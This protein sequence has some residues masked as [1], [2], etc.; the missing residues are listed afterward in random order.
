MSEDAMYV[1]R[2]DLL[3]ATV[4]VGG[5]LAGRPA[6]ADVDL[7]GQARSRLL[8]RGRG[9]Y[10]NAANMAPTFRSVLLAQESTARQV[11]SDPGIEARN[12]FIGIARQVRERL[13]ARLG[14]T[15]DEVALMRNCSEA[16]TQIVRGLS[17]TP[18]DEVVVSAQNHESNA[19]NWRVAARQQGVSVRTAATSATPRAPREIFDQMVAAITPRTK[20]V[21]VSHMTNVSGVIFPIEALAA[22][23]RARGIWFHVDAA[24]TFGWKPIDVAA[25]GC[26]SLS[27]SSQK[28]LM[29]PVGM[30]LLCVRRERLAQ[31][32]PLTTSHGYWRGAPET[33]M[34]GERFEDLGQGEDAKLPALLAALAE[35][36]RLG[37]AAIAARVTGLAAAL[38]ERLSTV[39]GVTVHGRSDATLYGPV[40]AVSLADAD[41]DTIRTKVTSQLGGLSIVPTQVGT[42]H[43]MRLSPHI[44]NTIGEFDRLAAALGVALRNG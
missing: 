5:A 40:V 34:N 38:R 16:N 11:Q 22:H 26:D 1:R 32:T 36:D 19:V 21:S 9:L 39:R 37:E 23:C 2:R 15:A 27:A 14:V 24:Q 12:R 35:R 33:A 44:Y 8:L 20:V 30:G 7:E 18:G 31:L 4:A 17:L 10:L 41:F 28:W 43:A 29:G 3:G 42:Q 25:I 13:A 6:R